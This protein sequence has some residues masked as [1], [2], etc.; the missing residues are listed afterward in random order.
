MNRLFYLLT[1]VTSCSL[2]QEKDLDIDKHLVEDDLII[3]KSFFNSGHKDFIF[4]DRMHPGLLYLKY[5]SC[6]DESLLKF[7]FV[8]VNNS[9]KYQFIKYGNCGQKLVTRNSN[10]LQFFENNKIQITKDSI[11]ENLSIDHTVFY[12]LYEFKDSKLKTYKSFC[13]ECI[14][15]DED[16]LTKSKN[17]NTKI[18]T[19]F[20]MLDVELLELIK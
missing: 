14:D 2:G 7:I 6:K 4:V 15:W 5:D 19:F 1:L 20:N 16:K 13:K 9:N 12:S 11:V 10:A 8:K 18:Y 17:Q 3:I